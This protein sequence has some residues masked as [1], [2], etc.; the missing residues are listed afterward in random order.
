M[1]GRGG[2]IARGDAARDEAISLDAGKK[3]PK[4]PIQI[5]WDN[6]RLGEGK[7]RGGLFR[8]D[9][10]GRKGKGK[11]KPGEFT[12]HFERKELHRKK[13]AARNGKKK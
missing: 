12:L 4:G 13:S 7:G 1:L 6:R 9:G 8:R 5:E 2:E 11:R 10:K 3:R